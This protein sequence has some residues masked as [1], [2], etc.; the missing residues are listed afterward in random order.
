VFNPFSRFGFA[1]VKRN[2]ETCISCGKCARVCPMAIP[3]DRVR[4]VTAARCTSCLDCVDSCPELRA[5]ALTW[6]PPARFGRNWPQAVLIGVMLAVVGS[7]VAASYLFPLPSYVHERGQ[8]PAMVAAVD[9]KV[10]DLTCRGRATL[11]TEFFLYRDDELALPGYL[12]VE[13]WPG[14]G[15]ADARVIY[16]PA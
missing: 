1:R 2:E 9:M 3:V 4:Q 6:G 11:F 12:R 10:S 15:L 8:K 14:P 13:A 7:A 5:G 16:D